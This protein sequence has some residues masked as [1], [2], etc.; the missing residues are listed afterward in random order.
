MARMARSAAPISGEVAKPDFDLA[1][2]LY[3]EDIKPAQS[4]V[5]EFAQEQST[6]YKAIKKRAN[7]QPAA[8]RTAFRIFEMEESKRDDYL[9]SLNGLFKALGVAMPHDLLDVAAG[10]Q[11]E[12]IIPTQPKRSKPKLVTIPPHPA[13]DSDLAGEEPTTANDVGAAPDAEAAE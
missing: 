12:E 3:R 1:V 4:R 9:R 2:K 10:Q 6:A 7:I 8:A 11:R 13:D 5:G